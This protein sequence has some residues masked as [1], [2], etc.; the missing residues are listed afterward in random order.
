MKKKIVFG[1]IIIIIIILICLAYVT[2]KKSTVEDNTTTNELSSTETQVQQTDEINNLKNELGITGNTELYVVNE[3]YDG[4]RTLAIKPDLQY[5]VV[6]AGILKGNMPEYENV[7]DILKDE[8]ESKGIW[9]S[10]NSRDK[11]LEILETITKAKYLIDE[12]GY[13]QQEE[14]NEMNEYDQIIN[15][16]LSSNKL[17]VID[18]NSICYILDNVTG[19]IVENQFEEMD[20]YMPFEYFETGDKAIFVI[21]TN[22]KNKLNYEDIFKEILENINL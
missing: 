16:I 7:N 12:N 4:R 5:N 17:Y 19:E 2:N 6:M 22:S 20:P 13:L 15:K 10:E 1:I 8:P 11:T 9:V 3:E 14:K 21:T 18:I